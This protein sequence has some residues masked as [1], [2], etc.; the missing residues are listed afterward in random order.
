M[1]AAQFP[2]SSINSQY[3]LN[4][5]DSII[6]QLVRSLS[7]EQGVKPDPEGIELA[8]AALLDRLNAIMPAKS[9]VKRIVDRTNQLIRDDTDTR[10]DQAMKSYIRS[11]YGLIKLMRLDYVK[12]EEPGGP[13]KETT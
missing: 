1:N 11:V 13:D 7:I 9:E 10:N 12:V 5:M 6:V 8:R 4:H 2:S 3:Y